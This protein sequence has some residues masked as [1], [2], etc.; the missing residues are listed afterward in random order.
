MRAER[1][2]AVEILRLHWKRNWFGYVLIA[3]AMLAVFA[4][5]LYPILEGFR[6]AFTNTSFLRLGESEFIGFDNFVSMFGNDAFRSALGFTFIYTFSTL[7]AAYVLA[8]ALAL[9]LN[10]PLRARGVF[11]TLLLIPWVIPA[12]VACANVIWILNDRYGLVN[13]FLQRWGFRPI[14]FLSDL[15][16]VRYTVIGT[17]VWRFFPF[18]MIILLAGMQAIPRELYECAHLD[19]AGPVKCFEY[20]TLPLL[21]TVSFICI[22]LSLIWIINDFATP[23]F[24]TGGGPLNHT[25][26]IPILSYHRAFFRGQLGY[27]AA[28]AV[29]MAALVVL[30][31]IFNKR[32]TA[33]R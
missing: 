7:F 15:G 9:Q 14:H 31:S 28:I 16:V 12:M 11:R 4:I 23:Y 27:A 33:N 22:T 13:L 3:P 26:T 8:M 20:I 32:L 10:Q 1:S 25:T 6:L 30:I 5:R 2:S 18:M 29:V 21:K 17:A 24:L 19:G